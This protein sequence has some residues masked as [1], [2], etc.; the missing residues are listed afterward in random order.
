MISRPSTQRQ[1]ILAHLEAGHTLTAVEALERFGCFRLAARV[2]E[3]RRA[4][5]EIV[6]EMIATPSGARVAEYRLVEKPVVARVPRPGEQG[7]LFP[8]D[9]DEAAIRAAWRGRA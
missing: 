1:S 8:L 5:H 9:P 2:E 6:S 7:R 3:L 4:G